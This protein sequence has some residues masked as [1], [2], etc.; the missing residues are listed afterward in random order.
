MA[1]WSQWGDGRLNRPQGDKVIM[2]IWLPVCLIVA[3]FPLSLFAQSNEI[4]VFANHTSFH[5]TT[6]TDPTIPLTAKLKFNSKVGYGVSFDHFLSPN[7]SVQLL[8]QTLHGNGKLSIRTGGTTFSINAGTLDV[9]EYDAALHWYF[10][11]VGAF[12]PYVGGG[13]ARI[14]GGKLK[15]P[16]DLADDVEAQTISLDSKVTW[17]ADAGIDFRVSPKAAVSLTAKYTPYS[18]GVGAA[19]DD[20]IQRLK[21]DPLTVAAGFRWRF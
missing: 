10:L 14:Q 6:D 17:V 8:A 5:S 18:S 20:A 12:R 1:A 3:L 15:I 16:A 13:V 11:P 21:L 19:P 2:R 9:N 4:A 7:L